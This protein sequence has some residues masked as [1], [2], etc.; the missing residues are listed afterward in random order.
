[1]KMKIS[2]WTKTCIGKSK[3]NKN[4]ILKQKYKKLQFWIENK[5]KTKD[6]LNKEFE[7]SFVSFD[8][9]KRFW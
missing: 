3:N 2:A 1:M 7:K 6:F 9:G 5:D 8:C 4:F